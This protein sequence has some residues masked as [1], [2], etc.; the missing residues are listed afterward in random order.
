MEV[1]EIFALFCKV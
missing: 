1:I